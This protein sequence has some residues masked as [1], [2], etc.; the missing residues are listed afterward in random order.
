MPACSAATS[1]TWK[2][3]NTPTPPPR[4]RAKAVARWLADNAL[5]TG[6]A[7]AFFRDKFAADLVLL[8]DNDFTWFT[9]NATVVEPHVRID[10]KT[11]TASD[12][13]LFYTENLPPKP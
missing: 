6:D 12:G 8:A 5:P 1:S 13:G 10:N 11:G 7:H 4:P 9:K 2:P 3:S